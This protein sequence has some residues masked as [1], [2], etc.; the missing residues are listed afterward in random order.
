MNVNLWFA[1]DNHGEITTILNSNNINTYTCPICNSEV[2]PKALES[3][4]I[5]P[6]FAHI[7]KNNLLDK[8]F[9]GSRERECKTCSKL[10]NVSSKEY[11]FY[12]GNRLEIPKRCKS[13]RNKRKKEKLNG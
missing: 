1:R 9:K 5:T 3:K 10:F 7:D 8:S 12:I 2:I 6:H 11:F 13:C 4:Q